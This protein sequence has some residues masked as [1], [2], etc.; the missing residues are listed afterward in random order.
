M[1]RRPIAG[2]DGRVFAACQKHVDMVGFGQS[3]ISDLTACRM[4]R[5]STGI[6]GIPDTALSER[7]SASRSSTSC[8]IRSASDDHRLQR[9][10]IGFRRPAA[11]QREFRCGADY[12]QR[13]AQFMRGV[14]SELGKRGHSRFQSLRASN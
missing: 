7:A 4:S 9:F 11:P 10:A 12:G 1:Q 6:S 14:G 3:F 5:R 8:V 2:D 13:R